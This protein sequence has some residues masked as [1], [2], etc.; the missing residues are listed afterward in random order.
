MILSRNEWEGELL[1]TQ[2]R[3]LPEQHKEVF[4]ANAAFVHAVLLLRRGREGD[5]VQVRDPLGE[6]GTQRAGPRWELAR[7]DVIQ[8]EGVVCKAEDQQ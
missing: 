2:P 6:H 8:L 7:L 3:R 4:T 1:L 5:T